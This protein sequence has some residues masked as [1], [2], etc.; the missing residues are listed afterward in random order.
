V[1][2]A[3]AVVLCLAAA[4]CVAPRR[5]VETPP[6]DDAFL[7]EVQ[8]AS[9]QYFLNEAGTN[10]LVQDRMTDKRVSSTMAGG[11]HLS[12]LCV[13]A[14]RGWISR[15]DAAQRVLTS[16]ETYR[17]LP[18]FHGMFAHY[19]FIDTEQVYPWMHATDDGADVSETGFLMAGVVACR[20]FF[21]RD[22]AAERR[23]RE[24]ATELYEAVEWDWMLQNADGGR[25][26]TLSWHWSPNHGFNVGLR[27][28]VKSNME[29]SSMIT[30]LLAIGSPTHPI[31]ADCWDE[32]WTRNYVRGEFS[33][34]SFILC[35]P[36][37]AHQYA[38]LWLDFRGMKDRH[39]DYFRNSRCAILANRDLAVISMYP[40]K[41]IW[42]LTFCDGPDGYGSYGY[43]P[44]VGRLREDGTIAPTGPGGSIVFAPAECI[45]SLRTMKD[46]YGERLWGPYG[47]R[48]SFSPS[49]NWFAQDYVAIDQGPF[50]MMIENYR[51]G[52]LWSTFMRDPA[53][54]VAL[55][56]AGFVGVV[57]DFEDAQGLGAYS[58]WS[59]GPFCTLQVSSVARREGSRSLEIHLTRGYQP[60]ISLTARPARH[61]FSSH[62][63]LS[64]WMRGAMG[65]DV[66]LGDRAGGFVDLA[67]AGFVE[68]SDGW[69]HFY[70]EI[71]TV[72]RI[73]PAAVDSVTFT[74]HPD[75]RDSSARLFLDAIY[76]N[77]V[78]DD[79]VPIPV[80]FTAVPAPTPGEAALHW[81]SAGDDVF[82]YLIRYADTPILTEADFERAVP[83]QPAGLPRIYGS[84]TGYDVGGLVPGKTIHFAVKAEDGAGNRSAL[85]DSL[86]VALPSAVAGADVLLD[87]AEESGAGHVASWSP[88]AGGRVE[89]TSDRA[90]DGVRSL[91][92]N[93]AK[94][95]EADRW[96]QAVA[97]LNYHDFSAH[98]YLTMWVSGDVSLLAKAWVGESSQQDIS[99]QRS[100]SDGWT[101]LVFDL[102]VLKS[103]DR[104][105]VRKL[106]LFPQPGQTDCSGVFYVDDVK[107][108]NSID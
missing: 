7:D 9:F 108:V 60:E 47:F 89:A 82:R 80:R 33:G 66:R 42:G 36:L 105:A 65:V 48:D 32:G 70:F 12:A 30:Y 56:R 19:Y 76:L 10:G 72:G 31:P 26:K 77:N 38:Q 11:F 84:M 106:L 88:P 50:V 85:S 73:D 98:R 14:E 29:L 27:Q 95:G 59:S 90:H 69:K 62:R 86:P 54:R 102:D 17:R 6:D 104:H 41:N 46:V 67:S 91:R 20:N 23:I 21:D 44:A 4:S 55:D 83:V 25:E 81:E 75:G 3:I 96:T 100:T 93:Y 18:R 87:D 99:T 107:L 37:F 79:A 24:L 103:V 53:I 16:L 78:R 64:F 45:S 71:P 2:S 61:D 57:D 39:A 35:P 52:K 43:P 68:N 28:R 74:A 101:N 13:G 94:A 34:R 58:A 49:R 15:E 51:S 5:A 92:M 40:G 97:D 63:L 8:R 22:E 1:I